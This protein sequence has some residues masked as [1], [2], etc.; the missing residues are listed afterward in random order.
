MRLILRRRGKHKPGVFGISPAARC[1]A[2]LL[3]AHSRNAGAIICWVSCLLFVLLFGFRKIYSHVSKYFCDEKCYILLKSGGRPC[4]HVPNL[5]PTMVRRIYSDNILHSP[6]YG[7][8]AELE[9]DG[10]VAGSALMLGRSRLAAWKRFK[11]SENPPHH[12]IPAR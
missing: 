2:G 8:L 7:G 11:A 4:A 6:K 12:C 1:T 3:G 10:C 5:S 9:F